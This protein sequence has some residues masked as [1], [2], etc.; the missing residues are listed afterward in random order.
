MNLQAG[1]TVFLSL[2]LDPGRDGE[3]FKGRLGFGLFGDV[4]PP[5]TEP[6]AVFTVPAP[7]E[8]SDSS[9]P[10]EAM[11]MTVAETGTYYVRVDSTEPGSPGPDT[12]YDLSTTVVPAEH[13]SCRTYASPLASLLLDG[14]T[15]NFP[16]SVEDAAQIGRAAVRLNLEE[17]VMADLNVSLLRNSAGA[18]V[19]LFADI[20][21]TNS[22]LGEQKHLEALFDEYAAVPPLYKAL[23]PL[24]LRPRGTLSALRGLPAQGSWSVVVSDDSLNGS[25]ERPRRR[26]D[27]LPRTAAGA[28]VDDLEPARQSAGVGVEPGPERAEAVGPEDRSAQVPR[29]EIGPDDPRRQE[30]QG[31]RRDLLRRLG[32]RPDERAGRAGA[33][34]AEG[35]GEVRP[36]DRRQCRQEGMHALSEG[37]PLRPR[38]RRGPQPDP[39]Q[40]AARR[41]VAAARRIPPRTRLLGF[42]LGAEEQP[43]SRQLHHPRGDGEMTVAS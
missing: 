10:S 39:L 43:G 30:G 15:L 40:R 34:G 11:T 16:I 1:D 22:G 25:R 20:G 3:S 19:P 2:D 35:G 18:E 14:G 8:A 5:N 13:P 24:D 29:G 41:Q 17:S 21:A 28:A 38:R 26:T 37:R 42:L 4:V 31:R 12:T 9:N 23:R 7:G 32:R 33:A 6:T 27:R 36:R